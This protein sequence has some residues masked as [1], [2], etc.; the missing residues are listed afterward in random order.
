MKLKIVTECHFDIKEWCN[1]PLM[2]RVIRKNCRLIILKVTPAQFEP[3]YSW[4]NIRV[5]YLIFAG[6]LFQ[7]KLF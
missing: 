2:K 4:S 1:F 5:L 6:M 3:P 7:I